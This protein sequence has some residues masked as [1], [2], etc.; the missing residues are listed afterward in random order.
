MKLTDYVAGY[1]EQLKV[2]HV[3]VVTGGCVVHMID[4]ISKR[5]E[6]KYIPVQHEQ[7]GAMA[8]EAYARVTGNIGVALATSGPGATN[9]VTGVCCAYYD[10][11]PSLFITGQVPTGQLK[12][13]SSSRQIG[14]Q[15]TDVVGIFKPITKYAALVDKAD[16]IRFELEKAVYMA[17]EGRPGPV[18]L[19]ICDDVQRA[20]IDPDK[21]EGFVPPVHQVNPELSAY[22]DKVMQLLKDSKRPVL[23]LGNGIRLADK[24]QETI[25]FAET[26][27]IPIVP[28]WAAVDFLPYA[29]PLVVGTF[30]VSSERAGNFCVQNSDLVIALGTRLD[31]HETGPRVSSFAREAKKIIVDIDAAE[32]TKFQELYNVNI[33][34]PIRADLRDF[35]GALLKAQGQA[36]NSQK[37]TAWHGRIKT[38]K[39][40][41]PICLPEYREQ[42]TAVNPYVF[43]ESL[44]KHFNEDEIILTDCGGNLIWTMQGL[45]MTSPKQRLISAFN[46]SPMGYSVPASVGA[47]LAGK[48]RVICITGDGGL[49]MNIQELA[50][51][52][53]FKLP[54]K[55]FLMNNHGHGIIKQTLD[56]WLGSNYNAVDSNSGLADPDYMALARVYGLQ[57][58]HIRNHAELSSQIEK[59]LKLEGPVFCNVELI[60]SQKMEPKLVFGKPIED[61]APLLDRAEF[62]E[63]MIVKPIS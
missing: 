45:R 6:L 8:A 25:K 62:Y 27:Q 28:T 32:L 17:K 46:H 35:M 18:L 57:S 26:Y 16:R 54:V 38:W 24:I 21:L 10:S 59:A 3:F 43:M 9:L 5:K 37:F 31:T 22:A 7:S 34:L 30:G 20:D 11:I 47:A 52:S 58:V 12:K 36:V 48:R 51:I 1:L 44:S 13:N 40:K 19:D 49:Q 63:N 29:H 33:D 56:T 42:K 15:E 50:T 23:I 2:G 14:F 61:S 39:E 60:P 4:S 55:I 41:Y 53:H